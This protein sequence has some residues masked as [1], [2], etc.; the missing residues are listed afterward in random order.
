[1]P[2]G[3]ATPRRLR[4]KDGEIKPGRQTAQ[5]SAK[6]ALPHRSH[7]TSKGGKQQLTQHVEQDQ[8][9]EHQYAG[10]ARKGSPHEYL[11]GKKG[12]STQSLKK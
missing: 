5:G 10:E 8:F 2:A 11:K 6:G 7:D 3:I 4:K 12:Y 1:M 9:Y